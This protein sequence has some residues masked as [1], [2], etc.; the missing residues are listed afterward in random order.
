MGVPLVNQGHVVG[1][2][3]LTTEN[4]NSYVG[5]S[6]QNIAMAF[7]SQVAIAEANAEL[8]EQ[9]FD[10]TNELGTLL[11]AAQATSL[12]TDLDSVFQTVVELMFSA[13][14]MDDCAI[15][16]WDDVD[17]EIE[18]QVDMNRDG[19]SSRVISVGT[20]FDLGEY[21]AKQR[22]LR[23]R[24]VIVIMAS[25]D[26][27][28]YTEEITE[29]RKQGDGARM[30]VP[31]V[32]RERSIG[33]IQLE[34]SGSE[35]VTQQK[36]RMA[37]GLGTQ[38]AVAIEN[39]RLSAETAAHFEES[40]IINELSHAIS[41]TLELDDMIEVVRDQVPRVTN[42]RELYVALYDPDESMITFPV[43]VK[44]G[45]TYEIPPRPLG[46]D[47]V[48]FI[49]KH[50]RPLSLGAD[51]FSPDEL[52]KSL[53]ITNGEG[54]AKSYLG[55]PLMAGDEVYGVL[56][57]RDTVRKR[58]FTV[59]EQRILNIVGPQ[60]GAAIQN[61]RLFK[62]V[63]TFADDLNQQVAERTRELEEERDRIDIL[64]QI[65]S[66]LAR[67]LDMERLMPRA[68]GMVATA[69][70]AADG[71]IMQLDPITDQL[72]SRAVLNPASLQANPD[73]EHDIHPS[74][75]IARWLIEEDEHVEI[76]S[77][78]LDTDYWDP[79][80]P[81]AAGW[82]SALAVLLETNEELLGVMVLL[83]KAPNAFVES[84][85]HM[86]VAAANQVASSI[87]N[88]ELYKL[89]RD[90][91]ER[92]GSLLRAEQE[93]A[94]KNKAILEGI[95]DGVVLADAEG[96]IILFNT[97][98][99]RILQLPRERAMG[100]SL[101][102]LTGIY[103][104]SSG[105]WAEIMETQ[106][107][108]FI[109]NAGGD[110]IDE[111]IELNGR[112]VSVH[113][114]PVYTGDKFLGTVSVFRDVT[115]EVEAD[116]SKSDFITNVSHE[117]R[118]PLTPIKGYIDM[119]LMGATGQVTDGQKQV[120]GTVKRNVDR[121]AAL[122]DD[123]LKISALDKGDNEL[124]LVD[125]NINELI[126]MALKN[127]NNQTRHKDKGHD[128]IFDPDVDVPSVRAD[129]DKVLQIVSNIIDNAY[130]YTPAGGTV[131]IV[132]NVNNDDRT[133]VI[134]VADT[135]VGIPEEFSNNVWERFKR[136]DDTA[137]GM[138]V[139]GTGL[140]MPIVKELVEMHGGRV[141]FESELNVGT[142]FYVELPIN[143]A[144]TMASIPAS[145]DRSN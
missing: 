23:E 27:T 90:Q 96:N 133:V 91:A 31:L 114:S 119:V 43:A 117:F 68:L 138:E 97:A 17:N 74:E 42:S 62:Q 29:L 106:M 141:W 26:E 11:E 108:E 94:E 65:T 85:L 32:V 1:M 107:G 113:L 139:A 41:S 105:S 3:M 9:T 46:T 92:L 118:T 36:V 84:H 52:R 115:R 83:S 44:D 81:G 20:R 137:L 13:L 75:S 22:S 140:G 49:I 110:Y 79:D 87:N 61:A 100:Q 8:F 144:E 129:A 19:D 45:E 63:S 6:D 21:P 39:A 123:V 111:R 57:V 15:M 98:A 66:E 60:L 95:A 40:M 28:P 145:D 33:L 104:G 101:N 128:V 16:I 126:D 76:I 53:G 5:V 130:N 2:M 7:A 121:L 14:D 72:Y 142:T 69:V 56:A 135:G 99:E 88:A 77:D 132:A 54:D 55:V 71:V 120:L 48:S 4:E 112:I 67:T 125:V 30:L 103:S 78:L 34:Q 80:A 116:R 47:E 89:I 131:T 18:V 143:R 109:T 127:L 102:Q 59:N 73:G 10:R 93:E 50:R 37:Q 70:N 82:R 64:Y 134:S 35:I 86:L 25:D 58:A 122:V 124:T 136:H 38:V 12:T 51:Y 24:E